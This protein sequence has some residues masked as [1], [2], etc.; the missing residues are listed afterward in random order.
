MSTRRTSGRHRAVTVQTSTLATLSKAVADNA[1]GVGRQAAVIAAASGL[2]LTSGI[3]AQAADAPAQRDSAPASNLEVSNQAPAP[4]SADS[5]VRI[6]FERPAVETTPA[7]VIEA[8]KPAV[9][10]PV[11]AAVAA[12]PAAAVKAQPR[13]TVQPQAA[14]A[15]AAAPQTAGGVNATMVSAAYAQLGLIQDCTRLVEKALG[16]AGIPV[17]DPAPM[18]FMNYGKVVGAPTPG[19]MVVQSGHVGIYVGN[20]QVLSS[21]MNGKNQT[22]VHPLS[23]LTA[24]GPVTFVRAGA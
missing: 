13:I 9:T 20:G 18:Q 12:G 10:A 19:D 15:P 16:A 5:S 11:P 2:V 4:L 8:P 3:A 7:P 21:G 17:G 22:V 1:G 6:S 14:T 23:W 24:T